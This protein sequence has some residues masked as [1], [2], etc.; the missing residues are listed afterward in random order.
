MHD[1]LN[2]ILVLFVCALWVFITVRF[3]KN[4]VAPV[5]SVKAT[6]IDKYTTK[7]VSKTQGTFK[8]ERH[9]IVFMAEGKKLSFAVSE[10]SYPGYKVKDKGIL[11]YKGNSIIDF[12]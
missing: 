2:S 9:I 5:K 8:R 10:F 12:S 4:R 11:K 6:V 3:I 1:I 7:T